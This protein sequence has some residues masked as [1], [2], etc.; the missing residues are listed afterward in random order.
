MVFEL[1]DWVI[2]L[3]VTLQLLRV[4]KPVAVKTTSASEAKA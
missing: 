3:N 2:P 1:D 4:D